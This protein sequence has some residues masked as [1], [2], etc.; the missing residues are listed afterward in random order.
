MNN[1]LSLFQFSLDLS[2]AYHIFFSKDLFM[3][4][5]NRI[6]AKSF[7]IDNPKPYCSFIG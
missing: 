1:S 4:K 3:I 5:K 7:K 2:I 6:F